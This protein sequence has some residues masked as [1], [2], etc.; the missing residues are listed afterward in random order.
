MKQSTVINKHDL[1]YEI[2]TGIFVENIG[3]VLIPVMYSQMLHT[4]KIEQ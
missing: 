2:Y 4:D 1:K 3:F